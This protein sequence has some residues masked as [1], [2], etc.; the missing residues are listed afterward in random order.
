[1][2]LVHTQYLLG[3]FYLIVAMVLSVKQALLH[4]ADGINLEKLL[5]DP[6]ETPIPQL[7]K[8]VQIS[9]HEFILD[10]KWILGS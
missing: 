7:Q 5:S 9:R 10:Y 8:A 6:K 4:F 2:P 1:M 3:M